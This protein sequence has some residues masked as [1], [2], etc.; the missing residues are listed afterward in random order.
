[1][2]P[3][4]TRIEEPASEIGPYRLLGLVGRG[5]MA[6]VFMAEHRHLDQV[7]AVKILLPEISLRPGVVERLLNEARATARLRHPA[8][9]EVFDCDTLPQGGAFIA[10]EYL[11]GEPASSWLERAGPL[12]DRVE[13]AA[14]L[15]GT[16]AD[17]LAFAH[18]H[19]V[20]HRDLKPENF[21]LIPDAHH[22]WRFSVKVLD[23]GVA[24][25]MN[26][27]PLVRT[28]DG[29]VIGTP[30]YMAPEQWR[31]GVPT[32]HRTDVYSLG[33]VLFEVLSGR[34]PFAGVDTWDVMRAHLM[35]NPPDLGAL[36][37]RT[38]A[39][40][41]QLVERMLA[42]EPDARP[43]SMDEVATTLGALVGREPAQLSSLLQAPP[44]APITAGEPRRSITRQGLGGGSV[45][46]ALVTRLTSTQ[47]MVQR[48]LGRS[49]AVAIAAA[50][51]LLAVL[52]TLL[53]SRH[54]AAPIAPAPTPLAL[55]SPPP[56]AAP[57]PVVPP[58]A[59]PQAPVATPPLVPPAEVPA[60]AH[61]KAPAVKRARQRKSRES[62]VYRPMGD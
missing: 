20:I 35:D 30:L 39:P 14:A 21:F 11:E 34:P 4:A 26:E 50:L 17:A 10:M 6:E 51:A 38:P 16:L 18:R 19:G 52:T 46:R 42:K 40:L 31:P 41:I 61:E 56:V 53:L 24:K 45:V 59:L 28:R 62:N 22:P 57:P 5:G 8:I 7:R 49:G 1:V 60:R 54:G 2:T 13:L 47:L 44:H 58:P 3:R 36:A 25:L 23:F 12:G 43:Q 15:I 29:A 27:E 48:R 55:P 9:V 32:D 33:C 37:P